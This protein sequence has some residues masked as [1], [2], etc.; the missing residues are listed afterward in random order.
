MHAIP[1]GSGARGCGRGCKSL[2]HL[3][4]RGSGRVLCDRIRGVDRGQGSEECGTFFEGRFFGQF[5]Q[6][7]IWRERRGRF[8]ANVE[9]SLPCKKRHSRWGYRLRRS[10]QALK[11]EQSTIPASGRE[12][13]QEGQ[14]QQ[15][16]ISG[17]AASTSTSRERQADVGRSDQCTAADGN[18]ED[19]ERKGVFNQGGQ[20]GVERQFRLRGGQLFRHK[21]KAE[22]SRQSHAG[23][24]QGEE[25]NVEE[26]KAAYPSV[27]PGSGRNLLGYHLA[28]QGIPSAYDLSSAELGLTRLQFQD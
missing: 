13:V 23:L 12:G 4:L 15:C 16:I 6:R 7:G 17:Q 22:G 19:L 10:Q 18:L 9:Q 3:G 8:A 28:S 14:G 11:G 5:P 24:P 1:S 25:G 20:Q 27:H 2:E 21:G 26:P